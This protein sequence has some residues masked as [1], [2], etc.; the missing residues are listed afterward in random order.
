MPARGVVFLAT[1]LE[2]WLLEIAKIMGLRAWIIGDTGYINFGG[3]PKGPANGPFKGSH[4]S[5]EVCSDINQILRKGR[6]SF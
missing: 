6:N 5:I 4:R 2:Q 3:R 1:K